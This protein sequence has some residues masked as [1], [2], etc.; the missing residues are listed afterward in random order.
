MADAAPGRVALLSVRPRFAAA[1]LDGSK[2]VELR[3]RRAHLAEGAVC[4]LY[5][6]SP[7]RALV[8]ALRVARTDTDQPDALWRRWG[9]AM[10]LNRDEFDSYLVGRAYACAIVVASVVAFADPVELPELRR[11]RQEFVTPQSY[12]FLEAGEYGVLLNGQARQIEE[13]GPSGR[14]GQR[15]D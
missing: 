7:T 8:G 4:L 6:S 13:L 14:C 2:S 12:R 11:R 1:L 9:A 3:R 5:A 10:A 15:P